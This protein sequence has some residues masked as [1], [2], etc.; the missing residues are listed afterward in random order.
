VSNDASCW[1]YDGCTT[2]HNF[3]VEVVEA[4]ETTGFVGRLKEEATKASIQLIFL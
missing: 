2:K 4:Q 1:K 3:D